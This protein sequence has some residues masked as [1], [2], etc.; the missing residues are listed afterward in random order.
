MTLCNDVIECTLIKKCAC[1]YIMTLCNDVSSAHSFHP[2]LIR[3][4]RWTRNCVTRL[5]LI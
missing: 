1:A 4:P 5:T 2:L 3:Y